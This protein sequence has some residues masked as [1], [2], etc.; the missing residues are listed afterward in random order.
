MAQDIPGRNGPWRILSRDV[1]YENPWIRI[2]HQDVVHPDGSDGIYGVVHFKNVAVGVLPVFEDGTVP[3]VGQH[4]FPLREYSWELPEGGGPIDEEPIEAGRR[5]LAEETGYVAANWLKLI[6]FDVSNSVTDERSVCYLAW[7][8]TEG[9]AGPEPSEQL[10]HQ[11]IAFRELVARCLDG[12]IRDSLTI[13]MALAADAM[14]RRGDLPD[15]IA[16]YLQRA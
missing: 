5:E 1:G 4:R 2:D 8:I 16:G 9:A 11:R 15:D 10:A 12:R 13:V 3:L 14:A 7:G 6:D